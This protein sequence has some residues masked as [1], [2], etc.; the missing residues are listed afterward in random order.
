MK[1]RVL[2]EEN[3]VEQMSASVESVQETQQPIDSLTYRTFVKKFNEEYSD[4]LNVDQKELLS[5]YISSFADNGVELKVYLNEEIGNLKEKLTR[6]KQDEEVSKNED[7]K[8]KIENVY[9][10]LENT[11][12]KAIDTETVEIVLHTQQ[13]IEELEENV[14]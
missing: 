7:L 11:K 10:I 1:D 9:N 14:D 6:A 13:L 12:D 5:N 2:L 8:N 4:S 3:I